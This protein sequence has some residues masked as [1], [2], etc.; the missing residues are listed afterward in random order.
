MSGRFPEPV[1][2]G[3]WEVSLFKDITMQ[4]LHVMEYIYMHWGG[5]FAGSHGAL[6]TSGGTLESPRWHEEGA[7]PGRRPDGKVFFLGVSKTIG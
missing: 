3:L 2:G 1:K 4:M 7:N 6:G 5:L